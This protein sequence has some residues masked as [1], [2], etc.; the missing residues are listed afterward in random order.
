MHRIGCLLALLFLLACE[1]PAGPTGPAGPP[2]A[3]GPKG[4]V[5]ESGTTE[6]SLIEFTLGR[7]HYDDENDRYVV[8]DEK[9]AP[10]TVIEVYLKGFF[11]DT[12]D[13]YYIPFE[14][15]AGESSVY[16]GVAEGA[17]LIYGSL[18]DLEDLAGEIFAVMVTGPSA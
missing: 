4:E 11:S 18:G 16:Y 14:T 15:Y 12:G 10:D 2:G 7:E 8:R 1:G 9:I 5:G 3:Q 13:P 17:I 6:S